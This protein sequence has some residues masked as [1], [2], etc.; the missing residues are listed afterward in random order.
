MTL[1]LYTWIKKISMLMLAYG[2]IYKCSIY[3]L[4]WIVIPQIALI[5]HCEKRIKKY[6]KN[7]YRILGNSLDDNDVF[8]VSKIMGAKS[9]ET[10]LMIGTYPE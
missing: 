3:M 10:V 5:A 4:C 8:D 1:K 9:L 6:E 2:L 7:E